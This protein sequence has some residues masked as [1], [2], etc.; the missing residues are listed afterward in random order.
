LGGSVT[1]QT[2]DCKRL[3]SDSLTRRPERF[4]ET[5]F[6]MSLNDDGRTIRCDGAGCAATTP[7]IVGLRPNEGKQQE[8]EGWL[9]VLQGKTQLHFC[10]G[11]ATGFLEGASPEVK[12][13]DRR[14]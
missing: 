8:T 9:F 7:A 3:W 14:K 2:A 4:Q 13:Y 10:P 11:C 12:L 5:D 6:M 1:L